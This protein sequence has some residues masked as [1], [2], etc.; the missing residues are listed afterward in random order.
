MGSKLLKKTGDRDWGRGENGR[1][2][3]ECYRPGG[4][5]TVEV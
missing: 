1:G 2:L 4:G 5:K 3:F